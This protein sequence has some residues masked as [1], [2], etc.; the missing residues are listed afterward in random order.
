MTLDGLG[1]RLLYPHREKRRRALEGCSPAVTQTTGPLARSV[2][3]GR[4]RG[5]F[6][7]LFGFAYFMSAT[8]WCRATTAATISS[9]LHAKWEVPFTVCTTWALRPEA[10]SSSPP[11]S[12]GQVERMM[13]NQFMPPSLKEFMCGLLRVNLGD[14]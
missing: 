14:P 3:V 6:A 11:L 4:A 10:S 8:A 13:A 1:M 12:I 7:P 9:K 5:A 2:R